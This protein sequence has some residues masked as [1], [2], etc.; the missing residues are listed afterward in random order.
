MQWAHMSSLSQFD[1]ELE[2]I[3]RE[4]ILRIA[5]PLLSEFDG[6]WETANRVCDRYE[7]TSKNAEFRPLI[8]V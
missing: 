2:N 7:M 8:P 4:L 1:Q 5:A 6:V 3:I